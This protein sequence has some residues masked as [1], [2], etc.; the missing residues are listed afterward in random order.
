MTAPTNTMDFFIRKLSPSA[1]RALRIADAVREQLGSPHILTEHI[2]VGLGTVPDGETA[3]LLADYNLGDAEAL[4]AQLSQPTQP[5]AGE[6]TVQYDVSRYGGTSDGPNIISLTPSDLAD[7]DLVQRAFS[8][9]AQAVSHAAFGAGQKENVPLIEERHILM[10]IVAHAEC[11]A[12]QWLAALRVPLDAVRERLYRRAHNRP[13]AVDNDAPAQVDLLGIADEVNALT[14]MLLLRDVTPPLAVG[15][16]GG[17]G[18]GKSSVMAL[19][20]ARMRTIRARSVQ[21]GWGAAETDPYVGHIY[22]IWFNAW[23]YSKADLGASLMQTIFVALDRQ[24]SLEQLSADKATL[25]AGGANWLHVSALGERARLLLLESELGQQAVAQW[26]AGEV[27]G[28]LWVVYAQV[29]DAERR[30]LQVA[31]AQLAAEKATLA[32][33]RSAFVKQNFKSLDELARRNVWQKLLDSLV[34]E[35]IKQA[36]KAQLEL[37][38]SPADLEDLQTFG[39]QLRQLSPTGLAFAQNSGYVALGLGG[40]ALTLFSA[41]VGDA[42]AALANTATMA[43]WLSFAGTVG[44]AGL[45]VFRTYQQWQA[46]LTSV[47]AEVAQ[48]L[49]SEKAGLLAQA[50]ADLAVILQPTRATIAQLEQAVAQHKQR[51]GVVA[52]FDSV[53]DFV[54]ARLDAAD[55]AAQLGVAHRVQ[56]DLQEL[57][58]ALVVHP[59]DTP[60]HIAAKQAFFPRGPARVV[61]FIDDLDR[62]P[63]SKVVEVLEAVKLLLSTRL[64]V[65]V[66]GL[67]TRYVTRALETHYRGVLLHHGEPSG[68][69]YIEKII[70]IP[71]R[72]RPIEAAGLARFLE[73]QMQPEA[74]PTP[75]SDAGAARATS[76]NEATV[77]LNRGQETVNASAALMVEA[78]ALSPAVIRFS[79]ADYADLLACCQ[80]VRLTPRSVKRLVNV[81]KLIKIYWLRTLGDDRPRTVKQAVIGLLALSA[82]YPEVMCA[83]FATLDGLYRHGMDAVGAGDVA[84]FLQAFSAGGLGGQLAQFRADVKSLSESG[85]FFTVSWRDFPWRTFN[86]A[87]SFSFVG[88]PSYALDADELADIADGEVDLTAIVAFPEGVW[89][90]VDDD[91]ALVYVGSEESNKYHRVDCR[92][93]QNIRAHHRLGFTSPEAAAAF[94]RVPC[95]TCRPDAEGFTKIV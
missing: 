51:L 62:C 66:L 68:L 61:L 13:Q 89:R 56:A 24:L 75:P 79:Q 92:W 74:V 33:Q 71:Y 19:M 47:Q 49:K 67:D 2:L 70:Q 5:G 88:D 22:P 42:V 23:T 93:A 9:N 29:H 31:Q 90:V 63:P 55:Y 41:W 26:Q 65:V 84:A 4:V 11:V 59:Q 28:Q 37:L 73:M 69:D 81:L 44:T 25:L 72:V 60:A 80:R 38:F 50:D 27:Q 46:R 8:S 87:R 18:S 43:A 86:L 95:G 40:L 83:V 94:G 15:I 91:A 6:K 36:L 35:P 7:E 14:E 57:T 58:D 53:S 1:K 52:A 32:T 12:A 77:G 21:H 3:R 20:Q 64:F 48:R 45:T 17:W 82:R 10:G 16:L 54:Q 30:A 34:N 39:M 76:A 85:A 78:S